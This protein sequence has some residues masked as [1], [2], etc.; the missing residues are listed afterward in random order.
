MRSFHI[1]CWNIQGLHS[2]TFGPKSTDPVFLKNNK[3]LTL[4]FSPRPGVEMM[5]LPTVPQATMK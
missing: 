3:M 1:S 5:L 2:S 4:L